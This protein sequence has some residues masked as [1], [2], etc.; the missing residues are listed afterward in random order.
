MWKDFLI[1]LIVFS[2]KIK[3]IESPIE[4][5]LNAI[6][7]SVQIDSFTPA[8]KNKEFDFVNNILNPPKPCDKPNESSTFELSQKSTEL[9]KS[10]ST[11]V[12]QRFQKVAKRPRGPLKEKSYE[13]SSSSKHEEVAKKLLD[14]LKKSP[15]KQNE[16]PSN[17]T[18]E[19]DKPKD[20]PLKPEVVPHDKSSS[21]SK[22]PN[23]TQKSHDTPN[24]LVT[25]ANNQT[26]QTSSASKEVTLQPVTPQILTHSNK[27]S[28]VA[29]ASTPSTQLTAS[30]Q[31]KK[32]SGIGP[33]VLWLDEI[34]P[35]KGKNR[36]LSRRIL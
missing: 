24:R 26:V 31:R 15:V 9:N 12:S 23:I 22:R 8:V 35:P 10:N 17:V 27:T 25:K 29:S 28:E 20:K 3:N 18:S 4:R 7:P 19:N 5:Y 1:H 36:R 2:T 33:K 16:L 11:Q 34:V 30:Q 6:K 14:K 21:S 32:D 13:A